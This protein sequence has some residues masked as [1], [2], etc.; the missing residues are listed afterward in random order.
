MQRDDL[1]KMFVVHGR[2]DIYAN[3]D[4]IW[5]IGTKR[6][7]DT[8]DDN[9]DEMLERA[10]WED[11]SIYGDF[12]VCPKSSYQLHHKQSVCIQSSR[13]TKLGRRK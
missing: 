8:T 1:R 3:G 11:H 2:Y 4:A 5:M 9:L 10:G 7:L 6:L 13:N 12:M